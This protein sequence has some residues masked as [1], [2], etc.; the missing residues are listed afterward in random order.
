[1]RTL[2]AIALILFVV[3][4]QAQGVL[5]GPS[6]TGGMMPSVPEPK[7][8]VN[9][10]FIRGVCYAAD[11][12]NHFQPPPDNVSIAVVIGSHAYDCKTNTQQ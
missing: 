5:S 12:M 9:V 7:G 1:M 8:P 2:F 10:D 3:P 11:A 4:A 6:I